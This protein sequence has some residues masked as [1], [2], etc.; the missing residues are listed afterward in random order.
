MTPRS[1]KYA[2]L[3]ETIAMAE[4]Q[5]MTKSEQSRPTSTAHQ[6]QAPKGD[7]TIDREIV[8]VE[9][10]RGDAGE[11]LRLTFTEATTTTGKKVAWHALRVWYRASDGQMRPSKSGVSIRAREIGPIAAGFAKS[12]GERT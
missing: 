12:V 4:Q 7:L 9:V 5:N 3:K 10:P 8:M 11:V 1:E 2:L 6:G